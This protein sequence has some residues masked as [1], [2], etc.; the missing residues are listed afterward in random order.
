MKSVLLVFTILVSFHICKAQKQIAVE[1]AG[2]TSFYSDIQ[3]AVTA[4]NSG[5]KIY[6]PGGSFNVGT[7]HIDKKLEM[8]G[9]GHN[10]DSTV[11]TQPT[12]LTGIITLHTKASYGVIEGISISGA[13]NYNLE[14]DT[15]RNFSIIRCNIQGGVYFPKS[16]FNNLIIENIIGS[17][18]LATPG[19]NAGNNLIS[20][21]IISGATYYFNNGTQFLNNIFLY[22]SVGCFASP[23]LISDINCT[24]ENNLFMSYTYTTYSQ[25]CCTF[26]CDQTTNSIFSHNVFV[27]DWTVDFG[28]CPG[29]IST[30]NYTAQPFNSI[31]NYWDGNQAFS[32]ADN[33]QLQNPSLYVDANGEQIGIYGGA[34]PWKTGSIPHN[35]HIQTKDING[36]T[37]Q[38]GNLPVNI[39]VAAQDH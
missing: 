22:C 10:P 17:Q 13:I 32:Y 29:C 30:S 37:D 9:V 3:T 4:S 18:L 33:F 38:I 27:E 2:N 11:A 21:N 14:D 19:G 15:I 8:Y 7:L 34:F 16:A 24:F 35:P 12:Y 1:S 6:I 20:N 26:I 23:L 39:K 28:H 31:F 5:D 25:C 36:S